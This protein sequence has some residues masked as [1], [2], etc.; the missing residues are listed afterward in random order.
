LASKSRRTDAATLFI[1]ENIVVR[2]SDNL[3]LALAGNIIEIVAIVAGL[4]NALIDAFL[5]N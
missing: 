1:I 5:A 4:S 2:A 3:A